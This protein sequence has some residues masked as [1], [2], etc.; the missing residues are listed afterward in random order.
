MSSS[1]TTYVVLGYDFTSIRDEMIPKDWFWSDIGEEYVCSQSKGNIQFFCDPMSSCHLYF[2]Y[3]MAATDDY[4]DTV[5]KIRP[6]A[7]QL[8]KQFVDNKLKQ[9]GVN[10]PDEKIPYEVLVFSEWY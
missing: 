5:T 6:G 7:F 8:Q 4:E 9:S 10:I 3:I 2:G 1:K